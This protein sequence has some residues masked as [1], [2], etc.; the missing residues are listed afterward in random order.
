MHAYEMFDESFHSVD[1][2]QDTSVDGVVSIVFNGI[3][4]NPISRK[5]HS[6]LSEEEYFHVSPIDM[7]V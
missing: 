3:P 1:N 7:V 4:H 2:I 5:S 6:F